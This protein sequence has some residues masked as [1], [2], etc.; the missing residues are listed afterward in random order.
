MSDVVLMTGSGALITYGVMNHYQ[1]NGGPRSALGPGV[2]VMS[3]TVCLNVPDRDNPSS[4]LS[5]LT[6]RA[7]L[8]WTGT[9]KGVQTMISETALMLLRQE[10]AIV[11]A[12][13]EYKHFRSVAE[14][15]REFN[16]L[17]IIKRSKFDRESASN[18]G[19]QKQIVHDAA[20]DGNSGATV[21][22]VTINLCIEGDSSTQL[23]KIRTR[24]DLKDALSRIASDSQ[25]EEC[26]LSGEVL[27]TPE[28]RSDTLTREEVYEDYP[29]LWM[30]DSY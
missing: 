25:V 30:L 4:I 18:F 16:S 17:S 23:S 1:N 12:G 28:D 22:V 9:R 7:E 24:Q 3:L 13:S 8:S 19:G 20:A 29:T 6:R 15:Q 26:L 14:A 5:A 27:W 21:A 10:T 2:S 11:S